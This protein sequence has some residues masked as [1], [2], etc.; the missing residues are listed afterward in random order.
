MRHFQE[1]ERPYCLENGMLTHR[2]VPFFELLAS[3]F[4]QYLPSICWISKRGGKKNWIK[5]TLGN[6]IKAGEFR[7]L[8]PPTEGTYFQSEEAITSKPYPPLLV[9]YPTLKVPKNWSSSN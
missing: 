4:S 9:H 1:T 6:A 5:I 2:G 3:F 8:I 7:K